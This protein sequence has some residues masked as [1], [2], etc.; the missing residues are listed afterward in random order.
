MKVCVP[1]NFVLDVLL[2][3]LGNTQAIRITVPVLGIFCLFFNLE[4]QRVSV[5]GRMALLAYSQPIFGH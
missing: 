4:L 3:V 2:S 5:Y 1:I